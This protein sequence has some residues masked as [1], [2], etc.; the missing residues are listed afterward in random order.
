MEQV[1][2]WERR[3]LP[4]RSA[5][6]RRSPLLILLRRRSRQLPPQVL[7]HRRR[8]H[9]HLRLSQECPLLLRHHLRLLG[10]GCLVALSWMS[11]FV[12]S[13]LSFNLSTPS[14]SRRASQREESKCFFV[15]C[16][17]IISVCLTTR[18]FM[19]SGFESLFSPSS[20]LLSPRSS[21]CLCIRRHL[22]LLH[23]HQQQQRP[24]QSLHHRHRQG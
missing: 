10:H 5:A 8:R 24:Q 23:H 20:T 12:R 2:A 16:V 18:I 17:S 11:S 15:C 19:R 14:T 3:I 6:C 9:R 21:R 13:L 7:R 4:C 1:S 22:H